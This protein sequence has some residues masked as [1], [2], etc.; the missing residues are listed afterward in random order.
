M[1]LIADQQGAY[2]ATGTVTE[3]DILSAAAQVHE[4][5]ALTGRIS[6]TRPEETQAFFASRLRHLQREEFHVA[7]LD[8]R[9]RLIACEVL[10]IGTIDGAEVHPR[11]VARA[12]LMHGAAAVIA[13]HN[14]PS[15]DPSASAADRAVT[16]R[17]KQA[18]ALLDIR[19][20]DH[21]I[22]GNPSSVSFAASGL[23]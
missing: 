23:I 15:G 16:T 19:L 2:I 1:A 3:D 21:I 10:S 13:A 17:L 20:L 4:R 14:H 8:A 7:F 6:F 9:H 22:V 18:L 5:R 11:E 12:A